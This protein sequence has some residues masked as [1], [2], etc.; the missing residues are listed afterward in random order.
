[1]KLI[2]TLSL[3]TATLLLCISTS[4]SRSHLF[5]WIDA[6]EGA[7]A[8]AKPLEAET[9]QK[10]FTHAQNTSTN[11]AAK[12]TARVTRSALIDTL[13]GILNDADTYIEGM[14]Q[15]I[16][17]FTTTATNGLGL[18]G[19]NNQTP[20]DVIS[21]DSKA[22]LRTNAIPSKWG[23]QH[24]LHLAT[25]YNS[26]ITTDPDVSS[27]EKTATK[28]NIASILT[29]LFSTGVGLG[30]TLIDFLPA[31][32][33]MTQKNALGS[34]PL[35]YAALSAD[36]DL[37]TAFRNKLPAGT[38]NNDW[39]FAIGAAATPGTAFISPLKPPTAPTANVWGYTPAHYAAANTTLTVA[40]SMLNGLSATQKLNALKAISTTS[41]KATPLHYAA[42]RGNDEILNSGF[43]DNLA[44]NSA[45]TALAPNTATPAASRTALLAALNLK[46]I[47][48]NTILDYA[49]LNTNGVATVLLSYLAPTATNLFTAAPT[50][51]SKLHN[52]IINAGAWG[53]RMAPFYG[54]LMPGYDVALAAGR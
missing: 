30:N 27:E 22:D 38:R 28:T 54:L 20:L 40:S 29:A 11:K 15:I 44:T 41:D 49:V 18:G 35:H 32:T 16:A 3:T 24:L 45:N 48:T 34:N 2:N 33:A 12:G 50:N 7:L 23:K 1:M 31:F 4:H 9:V 8:A 5:P 26:I 25:L 43:L 6:E 14:N 47:A 17:A 21:A 39:A 36:A 37:L 10:L 53:P 46:D 42:A 13:S 19:N 52:F 51:S